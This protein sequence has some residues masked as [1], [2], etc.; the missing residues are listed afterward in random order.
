MLHIKIKGV[1]HKLSCKLILCPYTHPQ[2]PD[3][4][5]RS[6]H[7][8]LLKVV[9]LHIKLWEM[10]HRASC[11]HTFC[12]YTSP[13]PLG[14]GQSKKKGKDQ[15]LIQSSTTPDKGYQWNS[16]NVII[17]HHKREPRGQPFPAG[18]HKAPTNRRA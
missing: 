16:D 12:P 13:R 14:L 3:G 18:D 4:I 8:L 2:P 17:R 11:K 10:E 9:M 5:K 7:F 6:K 1:E 15:E